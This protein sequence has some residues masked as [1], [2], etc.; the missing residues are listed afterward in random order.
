M[1]VSTEDGRIV[2]FS[3]TSTHANKAVS[4][5]GTRQIPTFQAVGEIG[6]E[7]GGFKS[8]VKDFEFL[9]VPET[10]NL[11]ELSL[12]VTGSSEGSICVWKLD[13]LARME[14]TRSSSQTMNLSK[15]VNGHH[16]N[17]NP[18]KA[19]SQAGRL[20]GE[21]ETGNRITCLKAFIMADRS[22]MEQVSRSS[23]ENTVDTDGGPEA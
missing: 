9:R 13:L 19:E 6:G 20:L 21:Y 8:R 16:E 10:G 23:L 14:R 17:S 18:S 2:F 5:D 1:A 22:A 4:S 11:A 3:T 15:G 12:I 7:V